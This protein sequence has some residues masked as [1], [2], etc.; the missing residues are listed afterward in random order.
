MVREKEGFRA[1]E[2]ELER[3][4]QDRLLDW[5]KKRHRTVLQVEGPRQVG[6]THEVRK[7]AY[8]HYEQVIYVNLVRDVY[9]FEDLLSER[10]F[11]EQ[12]CGRAELGPFCDGENT[13][14]IIDEIQESREVYNAIRDIREK[15][16]CDIIVS[17]SYLARTVNS[18]DFFLPAGIAY[19]RMLPLSFCEFCRAVGI[20]G[21]RLQKLSLY[22]GSAAEE[23]QQ[24]EEAYRVYQQI[25]GYPQVVTTYLKT[26]SLADCMDVL[27][28]LV[29]TFTAE[30]SR[31][32]TNSTALSIFGEVYRAV[33]V[34]MAKGKKGT[35]NSFLEFVANFV[36][37]SVKEPVSRN[38]VRAASSWLSYSGMI[39][40]CDLYN[41]GDVTDVVSRRRAYFS[42]TGIA[43]YVASLVTVPRETLEG[44]LTE[45]FAY[46][47]LNRLYQMGAGHRLVKGNKPCFSTCGDYELDFV[48]VDQMDRR[49]GIEVKT[50]DNRSKSLAFYKSKGLVDYAVRAVMGR[51][52]HGE[53][54][55]TIPV[56]M[57]GIRFPYRDRE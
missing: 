32:F 56:Y 25:G 31:F 10:D 55:D 57:L 15:Y 8:T 34:Q 1:N 20:E 40:Y 19:L 43:N 24:M 21:E 36:K 12:Y 35:G 23:Y 51:G 2:I 18:K 37:D 41:N 33:M 6:K 29:R 52:G 13:V 54:A 26:R 49:F 45:T 14:L 44:I 17:G 42:D 46:T 38:E 4:V 30:S 50:G 3:E 11:L 39:G 22:G 53:Q 9:G 27:E 16:E 47:E 5:K 7:F 48:V 28:D